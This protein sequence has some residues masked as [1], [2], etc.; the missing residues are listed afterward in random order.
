MGGRH[1]PPGR[2]AGQ[3]L[4]ARISGIVYSSGKKLGRT[5]V[6]YTSKA[7]KQQLQPQKGEQ[8]SEQ[9]PFSSPCCSC[10][11]ISAECLPDSCSNIEHGASA[12]N[13]TQRDTIEKNIRI[14]RANATSIRIFAPNL[15]IASHISFLFDQGKEL[16]LLRA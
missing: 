5:L 3:G 7:V 2:V 14:K 11:V 13:N 12:R 8:P 16:Y 10:K 15:L 4:I 6:T 1:T 9:Q